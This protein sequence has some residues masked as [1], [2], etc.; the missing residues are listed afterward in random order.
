MREVPGESS[1]GFQAKCCLFICTNRT[2]L[3]QTR[4]PDRL[5]FVQPAWIV[6][7]CEQ[8]WTEN[9]T[10]ANLCW[11]ADYRTRLN[12]LW[13]RATLKYLIFTQTLFC[14]S[15]GEALTCRWH[16][17][18]SLFEVRCNGPTTQLQPVHCG[19][20]KRTGASSLT[21]AHTRSHCTFQSRRRL[22][23][24]HSCYFLVFLL[25]EAEIKIWFCVNT[26]DW[27]LTW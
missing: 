16:V 17:V 2:I 8:R 19:S 12:V 25:W 24:G 20:R 23:K 13:I 4:H 18:S 22:K 7:R 11:T 15:L 21:N 9:K 6:H 3:K 10:L 27:D 26:S 1:L 5:V 14:A